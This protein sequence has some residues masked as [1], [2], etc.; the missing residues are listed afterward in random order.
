MCLEIPFFA[1]HCGRHYCVWNYLGFAAWRSTSRFQQWHLLTKIMEIC[2]GGGV[3]RVKSR[4]NEDVLVK[5][6]LDMLLRR[7][8]P[9]SSYCSTTRPQVSVEISPCSS[10]NE[11]TAHSAPN[12][13]RSHLLPSLSCSRSDPTSK[14]MKTQMRMAPEPINNKADEMHPFGFVDYDEGP[15]PIPSCLISFH[16]LASD[17]LHYFGFCRWLTPFLL[18]MKA[19]RTTAPMR[20]S[21]SLSFPFAPTCLRTHAKSRFRQ[22]PFTAEPHPTPPRALAH[23]HQRFPACRGFRMPST[24]HLR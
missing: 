6:L 15:F 2:T 20:P 24:T 22:Q 17:S 21:Q 4:S 18:Q 13:P 1:P 8:D 23:R 11:S 10:T 16:A 3:G 12:H 5:T 19:R 14:M 9:V 7:R